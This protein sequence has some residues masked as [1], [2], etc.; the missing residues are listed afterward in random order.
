MN[1]RTLLVYLGLTAN[2]L[3][4][5]AKPLFNDAY[6]F[7]WDFRYVQTPLIS[8][9]AEELHAGIF[10]LW[11]PFTYCGDP[12]FANIQ[13]GF[14]YPPVLGAAWLSAHTSLDA[15]PMI[16]E[17]VVVLHIVFAGIAAFH[18][19]REM[20][21]GMAGAFAGA[22]IFETGGF[23]ASQAQ[24]IGAIMSVAPMPLAW[25]AV[26]RLG[27]TPTFGWLAVLSGCLGMSVLGGLPQATVAVFGSTILLALV[28]RPRILPVAAV[29]CLLGIGLS[30]IQF[31]PTWQVTQYSVAKY[32]ADWLGTGGG[33]HW[34]AFVSL[35]L[36]NH[37]HLFDLANFKGPGDISFLYIYGSIAGLIFAV[38]GLAIGRNRTLALMLLLSAFWMLGDKTPVWRAIF[39]LL[40]E[41]IRIGI[42]PEFTYCIFTLSFAGLAAIGLERLRVKDVL[43]WSIAVIIALDLYM[44]G[45]GR[46]MNC[47]YTLEEPG[48]TREAFDGSSELLASMRAVVN[49]ENPPSRIDTMDAS[50]GWAE[51]ATLTRVPTANGSSPLALENIVKLQLQ[52]LRK[53]GVRWGWYYQVENPDAPVLGSMAVK[54]LLVAG[55]AAEAL[56]SD[57]RYRLAASL[58]GNELFEYLNAQPRFVTPGGTVRTVHYEPNSLELEVNNGTESSLELAEA[59]YPGW[60]AWVDGQPVGVRLSRGAFRAVSVPAGTHRVRMEFRPRILGIGAAVSVLTFVFLGTF[61]R[62]RNRS[63]PAVPSYRVYLSYL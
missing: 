9:L 49:R 56:K 11:D 36:P 35:V 46:P 48:I 5:F 27:R 7:P 28:T 25:L 37:Y 22:M 24:H 14:F 32:R 4:F 50:I 43:R 19:F 15:L 34:A 33:L 18:L 10:P 12:I 51:C 53:P 30:A 63:L 13:A 6:I 31:L 47:T 38:V 17:W 45:S 1:R 23:F 41:S 52:A 54:Y 60:N 3:A 8:F 44:V 2:V 55:K 29:A 59:Y 39:P 57:A 40:P 20:G 16:L 21:A 26:L 58:P 62:V 42:H 61:W